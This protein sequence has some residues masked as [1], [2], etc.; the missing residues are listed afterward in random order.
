MS[1]FS[2][3]HGPTKVPPP[4]TTRDEAPDEVR[5]LLLDLLEENADE[6][7]PY[8]VL[9]A[10]EKRVPQGG[11]YS[12]DRKEAA[13]NIIRRLPW[14][15]VYDLIENHA[16]YWTEER[17]NTVF[18]EAGVG[19]ELIDGEISL[20]EP[21]ADELQVAGV[22][23]EVEAA[24]DPGG[25]FEHPKAQYLQGLE[26]L[27]KKPP[28]LESAV[29]DAVNAVEGTVMVITGE[30]SLSKGLKKL[31]AKDGTRSPLAES[32][33]KLFGYGS[34]VPGVRH[35]AHAASNLN[36]HEATYVVRAAGSAIA[37]LIAAHYEGLL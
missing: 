4:R 8:E 9:C 2:K 18:A 36:E 26:E 25:K 34:A 24:R 31:Y 30:S 5:R 21:E 12:D 33:E 6:A 16:G 14:A 15:D 28:K 22:E 7:D 11:M 3:R 10:H 27:R 13:Q 23:D 29:D 19:Y 35:G 20:Y 32:M 17:V 1:S 37:Y